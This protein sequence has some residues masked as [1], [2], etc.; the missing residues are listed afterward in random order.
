MSNTQPQKTGRCW[1]GCGKES[2]TGYFA[3]GHDR[4]AEGKLAEMHYG[5]K[6]QMLECY[7]YGA[8]GRNLSEEFAKWESSGKPPL[9]CGDA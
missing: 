3:P 7:G 1:C 4:R 8:N 9:S 6:A 2:K 5:G